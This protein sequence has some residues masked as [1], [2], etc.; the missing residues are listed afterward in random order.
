MAYNRKGNNEGALAGWKELVSK[1]P[2]QSELSIHLKRSYEKTNQNEDIQKEMRGWEELV[3]KHPKSRT[4]Q[5]HLAEVYWK[6]GDVGREVAGWTALLNEH[7]EDPGLRDRL[8]F[9]CLQ[10][11]SYDEAMSG[12]EGLDMSRPQNEDL[13]SVLEQ[14]L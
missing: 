8:L 14:L 4:L 2:D 1:H 7:P 3:S 6:N 13:P 5:A 11:E 9:A 12:I 10:Y